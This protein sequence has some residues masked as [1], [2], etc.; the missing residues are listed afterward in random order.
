MASSGMSAS[1]R[2]AHVFKAIHRGVQVEVLDVDCHVPG[3]L[4]GDG[5]VLVKLDG[6]QVDGG[7]AA[8]AWIDDAVPPP[9]SSA[10][11]LGRLLLA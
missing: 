5:A 3:V 7:R 4:G 1:L 9:L 10:S 8:V 2:R 11:C 6:E